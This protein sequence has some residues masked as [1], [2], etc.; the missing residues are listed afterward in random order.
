MS[1]LRHYDDTPWQ[2]LAV[3]HVFRLHWT[4]DDETVVAVEGN[5]I[6]T[7]R[8]PMTMPAACIVHRFVGH[9]DEEFDEDD[10]CPD[11]GFVTERNVLVR[12]DGCADV[13]CASCLWAHE[14]PEG[15]A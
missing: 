2:D 14:P 8:G 6:T 3:G 4:Y 12:A 1:V 5:R 10:S 7:S 11:C 9:Y 15:D 13:P